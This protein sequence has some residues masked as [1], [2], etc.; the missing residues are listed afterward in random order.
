MAMSRSFG[1]RSLTMR[2]PMRIVPSLISSR[3]ATIRRAVVLPHPEGPTKTMNSP[4]W[5]R[6]SSSSTA[7]VPSGYTLPTPWN[8][9]SATTAPLGLRMLVCVDDDL[10]QGRILTRR[11]KR[12]VGFLERE[13][14]IDETVE[15]DASGRRERD[16][17][18]IG[19]RVAERAEDRELAILHRRDGDPRLQPGPH[20]DEHG[21]PPGPERQDPVARHRL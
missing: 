7:R 9:M 12:A 15:I 11:A 14:R 17:H 16:R 10:Q 19:V 2:S 5:M 1:E 13:P 3:P 18:R 20:P 6:R 4:S 8:S 21:G